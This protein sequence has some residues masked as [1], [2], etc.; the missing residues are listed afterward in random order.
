[1]KKTFRK[2]TFRKK[3]FRK[4]TLR[5]KTLRKRRGGY[6]EKLIKVWRGDPEPEPEP[7]RFSKF[8]RMGTK[9]KKPEIPDK[10]W[11]QVVF[12]EEEKDKIHKYIADNP[13]RIVSSTEIRDNLFPDMRDELKEN[14]AWEIQ[15]VLGRGYSGR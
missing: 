3:T 9:P 11:T 8:F 4:K 15:V 1:M 2:K 6:T 13:N 14:A 7:N 12:T 10:Y 5:K